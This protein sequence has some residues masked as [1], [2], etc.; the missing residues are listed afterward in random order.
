MALLR[1]SFIR[2][3]GGAAKPH[4]SQLVALSSFFATSMFITG[5][6]N[7][8]FQKIVDL[9]SLLEH[10]AAKELE[11]E[12]F[13]LSEEREREHR[14]LLLQQ[15][16]QR[17]ESSWAAAIAAATAAKD[18]GVL[19]AH[20]EPQTLNPKPSEAQD[21]AASSIQILP[22]LSWRLNM[23]PYGDNSSDAHAF[24]TPSH[25]LPLRAFS[26]SFTSNNL[27]GNWGDYIN[28]QD[29]KNAIMRPSRVMFTDVF[30]PPTK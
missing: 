30:I 6:F 29:N 26:L 7:D 16:E 23:I 17:L 22:S 20:L 25:E 28:R 4:W 24:P 2:F 19:C 13:W 5:R 12:G 8:T 18:F 14:L 1:G 27:S 21:P 11:E 3:S 10:Q 9:T 15:Q